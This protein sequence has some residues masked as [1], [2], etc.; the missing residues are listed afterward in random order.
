[1]G[2][3]HRRLTAD[4][5]AVQP[6]GLERGHRGLG[7]RLTPR[8]ERVPSPPC[9]SPAF[10]FLTRTCSTSRGCCMTRGSMTRLGAHRRAGGRTEA[11]RPFDPRS[12]GDP[13]RARRSDSRTRPASRR[14]SEGARVADARRACSPRATRRSR[15]DWQLDLGRRSRL[16]RSPPVLATEGSALR[17]AIDA[18]M[19]ARGEAG[20]AG[21]TWAL[22]D[23]PGLIG[24]ARMARLAANRLRA[25]NKDATWG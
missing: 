13:Q 25:T 5:T 4:Q 22:V 21:R 8:A 17:Q 24:V 15:R 12:G 10:I 19:A 14:A 9:I 3:E 16:C 7:A 6:A 1:M 20:A 18:R 11:R 23:E 2:D